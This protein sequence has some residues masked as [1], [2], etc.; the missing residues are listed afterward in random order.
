M[1][2]TGMVHEKKDYGLTPREQ[3]V[4][5]FM[6]GGL[7]RKQI[8]EKLELSTHTI[9]FF[10]RGI[11]KKLHVQCQTAAISTAMRA[12]LIPPKTE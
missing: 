8:A 3:S 1:F 6:A 11:Y 2:S 10:I 9:G 12:G 7:A 4:L 5:E